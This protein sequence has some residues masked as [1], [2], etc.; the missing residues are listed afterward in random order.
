MEEAQDADKEGGGG[1]VERRSKEVRGR[2][3]RS[4]KEEGGGGRRSRSRRRG[5]RYKEERG[6]RYE[7]EEYEEIRG[8]VRRREEG[9]EE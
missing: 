6:G 2:A 5:W 9:S 7:S 1:R 8:G 3:T 4:V